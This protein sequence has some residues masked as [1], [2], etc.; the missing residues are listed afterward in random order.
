[1]N[2]EKKVSVLAVD[3]SKTMLAMIA[4]QLKG[5]DFEVVATAS[6]GPEAVEKF[7]QHKPQ[8]VLLDIVMPEVSG[9]DTLERLLDADT[10]ACVVMV[11][12]AGT[13]DTV[14]ACLQKGA[15]SFLQKPIHKD[16][17]LATLKNVCDQAGVQL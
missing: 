14:R 4:S 9:I 7:K 6:S 12:S 11:S 2:D 5:S 17:M 8:L 16:G 3:D 13:E 15:K 1:M 10:G